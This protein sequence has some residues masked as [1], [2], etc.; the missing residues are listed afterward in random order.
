MDL[1]LEIL[2][3]V[4][5][6]IVEESDDI[7]S[8]SRSTLS[9]LFSCTLTSRLFAF[10]A[11]RQIFHTLNI[12]RKGRRLHLQGRW[13]T[14]RKEAELSRRFSALTDLLN[15]ENTDL[16]LL[17][18]TVRITIDKDRFLLQ[19]SSNLHS[20]FEALISRGA[21]IQCLYVGVSYDTNSRLSWNDIPRLVASGLERISQLESLTRLHIRFITDL[22]PL[23][24]VTRSR[25]RNLELMRSTFG[26]VAPSSQTKFHISTSRGQLQFLASL[27]KLDLYPTRL[28]YAMNR[29][30]NYVAIG[31]H[32]GNSVGIPRV[33][34][35]VTHIHISSHSN[36][37]RWLSA[38]EWPRLC[39]ASW[40]P[41]FKMITIKQWANSTVQPTI[42][43]IAVDFANF[44]DI[45]LSTPGQSKLEEI[46]LS[47]ELFGQYIGPDTFAGVTFKSL[48]DLRI[49]SLRRQHPSLQTAVF[50]MAIQ[51]SW[52]VDLDRKAHG[53]SG[54]DA[55]TQRIEQEIISGFSEGIPLDR[56]SGS[57]SLLPQ[58]HV[59]VLIVD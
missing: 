49:D 20:V 54:C 56:L 25:F 18:R 59:E 39:S 48:N 51:L 13:T 11:R 6:H 31:L 16:P 46:E 10:A 55:L 3:E 22:P 29:D 2:E 37:K 57:Q 45:L 19:E 34:T 33:T 27:S 58:I 15:A 42:D 52:E 32:L 28:C 4:L 50:R 17:I 1:P 9:T 24:A 21:N 5:G 26:N 36:Q 23:F 7:R 40:F 14:N 35:F 47:Y 8:M 53:R 38:N 12:E 41:S 43:S 30:T 44:V